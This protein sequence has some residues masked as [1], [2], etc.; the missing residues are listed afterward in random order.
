M[1][2]P[3]LVAAAEE[4]SWIDTSDPN[5]QAAVLRTEHG[6]LLLPIWMGK[7]AQFVPGQ[8]ALAKLSITVPQVPP[9]TQ[10]WEISPGR[11][12]A[13][14]VERTT[15]GNKITLPEFGLTAAVVFAARQRRFRLPRSG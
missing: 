13:L 10:A 5:V 7:G 14:K 15:G 1:L 6:I 2:E 11:I 8:A 9:G 3:L 12:H 4:P